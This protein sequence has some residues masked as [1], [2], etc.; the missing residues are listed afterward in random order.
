MYKVKIQLFNFSTLKQVFKKYPTFIPQTQVAMIR[1]INILK[2][3]AGYILIIYAIAVLTVSSI[4][5]IPTLKIH[6]D[7]ADIRLDYII[8][9]IEY[10][11]LAFLVFLY[12]TG[13]DYQMSARKYILVTAGLI[14]FAVLDEF[15]QKL[16]PGRSFNIYDMVSNASGILGALVFSLIIFRRISA[17][18]RSDQ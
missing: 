18:W 3:F 4:P 6:T 9:F 8:H 11:I 7:K 10:G 16:I 2:P 5:S 17:P 1:L 14:I 13:K 15:H 12:F